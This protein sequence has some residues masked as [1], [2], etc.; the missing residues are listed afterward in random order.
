M[1]IPADAGDLVSRLRRDLSMVEID[2]A[3][4]T[5][6]DSALNRFSALE[7]R[8]RLLAALADARRHRDW[9][10][11]Q[12]GFLAELDD[13]TEC[14]SDSTVFEEM[15][16]LFDEIAAAAARRR[17]RSAREQRVRPL[18]RMDL[19]II[20]QADRGPSKFSA[21]ASPVF[22]KPTHWRGV[23]T[24]SVWWKERPGRSPTRPA[25]SP[26]QCC[27]P[28]ASVQPRTPWSRSWVCAALPSGARPSP[29]S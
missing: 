5:T 1:S 13:I 2:C 25:G 24:A 9:I 11:A 19:R 28:T 21:P 17:W 20:P 12:L 3:C 15:A 26:G 6:L 14:E 27:R 4:R 29:E 18:L 23:A 8:R 7:H 10:A 16:L 22:G